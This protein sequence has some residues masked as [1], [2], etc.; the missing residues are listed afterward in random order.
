M[1]TPRAEFEEEERIEACEPERLDGEKVAGDDRVGVRTQELSP[2][3]LDASAGRKHAGLPQDLGDRRCRDSHADTG[4]FTD[5]PPVAPARVLTREPQPKLTDLLRD[6][7]STRSPSCIRPPSPHKL[8]SANPAGC[9]V[10]RR[11]IG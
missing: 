9:P 11:T 7:G 8:A 5:D 6:R 1:H 3:E 4:E 10:G 2:A